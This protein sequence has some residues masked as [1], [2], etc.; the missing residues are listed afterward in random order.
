[1]TQ[2]A[3]KTI[4]DDGV[5]LLNIGNLPQGTKV[6]RLLAPRGF[7]SFLERRWLRYAGTRRVN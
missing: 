7:S 5:S 6:R 2:R 4:P 1:M 3:Q